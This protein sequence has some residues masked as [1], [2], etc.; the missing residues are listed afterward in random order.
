MLLRLL[1]ALSAL[2]AAVSAPNERALRILMT[3]SRFV[4]LVSPCTVGGNSRTTAAG[5]LRT[6]SSFDQR[7]STRR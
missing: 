2:S 1:A 5:W 7:A 3:D 4:G 6:V